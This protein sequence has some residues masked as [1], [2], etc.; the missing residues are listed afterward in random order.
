MTDPGQHKVF[1]SA[2]QLQAGLVVCLVLSL[3]TAYWSNIQA[4]RLS[5]VN[6]PPTPGYVAYLP[7]VFRSGAGPAARRLYLPVVHRQSQPT[8]GCPASSSLAWGQIAPAR[9]CIVGAAQSPDLTRQVRGWYPVDERLAFVRYG[10]PIGEPP[11]TQH[12]LHLSAVAG[13]GEPAFIETYQVNDWD[14][15]TMRP[16]PRNPTPYPVT[17]LGLRTTPGQPLHAAYRDVPVDREQGF[18]ALVLYADAWQLTLKYTWQDCLDDGGYM[19]H[20]ENLCVDPNL[21][22]LYEQLNASGRNALPGVRADSV[23]GTA[24]GTEVDVVVRDAGSFLDPRSWQDW[25]QDQPMPEAW[26]K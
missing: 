9:K 1:R 26:R 23:V 17:M 6:E 20:L 7:A 10:Y 19:V 8:R 4:A 16:V 15:L 21:V 2:P 18:I 12:P 24:A 11:D 3:L 5:D 22:A 25:W 14:W 13:A